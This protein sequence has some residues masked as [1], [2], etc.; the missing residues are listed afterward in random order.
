LPLRFDGGISA[1]IHD[2]IVHLLETLQPN[3][4]TYGSGIAA[5]K[6]A[7]DWI[8]TETGMPAYPVWSSGC[9]KAG[10]VGNRGTPPTQYPTTFC[11]KG[12]DCTL[13]APDHWFWM[14]HTPIKS[15]ATLIDMYHD[16][17]G[18]NAVMEL[19]FA[20]DRTGNID[21]SH[22]RRYVELGSWIRGCYS[23]PLARTAWALSNSL[24]L[25]VVSPSDS[26][27]DAID[28]IVIQEDI[29]RGQRITAYTVDAEVDGKWVLGW[30]SGT[31]VGHKRIQV[32]QSGPKTITR[33]RLNVSAGVELPANISLA[34][35]KPCPSGLN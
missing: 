22:A 6:N 1:S 17:V 12:A 25:T 9:A 31:A 7:V 18:A 4:V 3:A 32:S 33:L 24:E 26:T 11:P 35:F 14:P 23:T 8:G 2:R 21:P 27:A 13:Q 28:R 19:D 34:A 20:I 16:S 5:D 15:L 10:G 30:A 29:S